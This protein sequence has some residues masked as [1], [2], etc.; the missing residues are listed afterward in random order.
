MT[1]V[2]RM[3]KRDVTH[4]MSDSTK[5]KFSSRVLLKITNYPHGHSTHTILIYEKQFSI[6]TAAL[7][8]VLFTDCIVVII[9][10][11]KCSRCS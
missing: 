1:T 2:Q 10:I 7:T 3:N 6:Q 5:Q 9:N 11:L 8:F 4:H